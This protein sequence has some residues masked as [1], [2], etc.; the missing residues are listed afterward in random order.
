MVSSNEESLDGVEEVE[1][2][3][4]PEVVPKPAVTASKSPGKY[5]F[6]Q[7]SGYSNLKVYTV[8]TQLPDGPRKEFTIVAVDYDNALML[9]NISKNSTMLLDEKPYIQ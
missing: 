1:V 2:T 7:D 6:V 8:S 5:D 3:A 4:E 9:A